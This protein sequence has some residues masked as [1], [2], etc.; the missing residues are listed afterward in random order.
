MKRRIVALVVCTAMLM[1]GC[2]AKAT[3]EESAQS[4]SSKDEKVTLKILT[5]D[6][7]VDE[8]MIQAF[9][10]E[11]P[12]IDVD[13]TFVPS[14]DY[15][16]KFSALASSNDIPDVLWTQAGY[17]ADQVGEGLLMDLSKELDGKSYEGDRTWRESFEPALLENCESIIKQAHP[18]ETSFDYAVPFSMV[19]V[20]V[21]YDKNVYEKLGLSVPETWE[22]FLG[23]CEALKNE[24]LIPIS[25]QSPTTIDWM[26]RLFWDQ[27]CRKEL[28]EEGKKFEDGT[29]TFQT[30]SV[31][32]SLEECKALWDKGYITDNMLTADIE[33]VQ[34]MFIQGKLGHLLIAPDKLEYLMNNAPDTME[35]GTCVLPGIAGLPS[36]SMGGSG[37]IFA[38]SANTEHPEEAVTFLKYLTSKTNFETDPGLKYRN[39]GVKGITKD[40]AELNELLAGFNKAAENGFCPELYVP[41]TVTTEIKT[42]FLTD[43]YPNYLMGNYE[44]DDICDKLQTMYEE[45]RAK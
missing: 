44:L 7:A 5:C 26:P 25:V 8:E 43:L 12:N 41:V 27:F 10:D 16:G 4:G 34:Q 42:A 39:A 9:K 11:N 35:L 19:S 32:K 36:R 23:N 37:I 18:N 15:A 1:A 40:D 38:A 31:K 29:M 30:E 3:P 17:Y 33:T 6:E 45:Y 20:A 22:D 24:G 28:D 21:L 13:L 14:G 2:G